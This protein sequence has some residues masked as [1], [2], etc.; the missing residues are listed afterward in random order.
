MTSPIKKS[1]GDQ[2]KCKLV[3]CAIKSQLIFDKKRKGA[4]YE[5]SYLKVAGLPKLVQVG[6]LRYR[7]TVY[8]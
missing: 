8:F 3:Y 1:R 7:V 4:I 5:E 6:V 2:S